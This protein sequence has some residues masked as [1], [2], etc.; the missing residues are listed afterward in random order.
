MPGI[1]AEDIGRC[2]YGIF[3]DGEERVGQTIGVAGEHLS[4]PEMAA[5]LESALGEPVRYLAIE[6]AAFRAM[7]FP[8]AEDLGNMFQFYRD[9]E[10]E[11][12]ALRSVEVS[13]ELNPSL[14]S[15]SQWLE[16]NAEKIPLE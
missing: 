8:G 9:F 15:F 13:R 7:G 12:R 2:A 1:G 10:T 11:F 16:V 4:G 5:E 6:P 3:V 14:Q